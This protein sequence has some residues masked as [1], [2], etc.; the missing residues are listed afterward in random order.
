MVH[1]INS[2]KCAIDENVNKWQ[3]TD[4][5]YLLLFELDSELD[6]FFSELRIY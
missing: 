6:E 4:C 3:L 1:K 2:I 5:M